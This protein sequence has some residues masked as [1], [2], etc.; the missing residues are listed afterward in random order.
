M[1]TKFNLPV[2]LLPFLTRFGEQ[3]AIQD[4]NSENNSSQS[5]NQSLD[6]REIGT[7]ITAV[8]AES[9]DDD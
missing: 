1:T 8:D 4:K 2:D 7:R 6:K 3:I 9:T 5:H